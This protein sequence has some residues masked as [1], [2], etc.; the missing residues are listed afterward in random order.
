VSETV[1]TR[2]LESHRPT[3]QRVYDCADVVSSGWSDDRPTDRTEVVPPFRALLRKA[4]ALEA[5][6][7]A[8]AESL[9][10]AGYELPARPV[11]NPPYVV[12]TSVG[13]VLRATV[14]EGRLVATL[15]TFDVSPYERVGVLPDGLVVERR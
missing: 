1:R 11:P 10:Y 2:L 5:L 6:A 13:V 9:T 14:S 15:R 12:V 3:L 7:V 8:W 4:S